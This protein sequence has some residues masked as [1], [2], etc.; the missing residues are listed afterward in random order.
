MSTLSK[1][2][3]S[4]TLLGLP[5][6]AF[7]G[8]DSGG[9]KSSGG[10]FANHGSLGES[11]ATVTTQGA[12][13]TN[14]PGLIE[15]LYPITPSSISDIGGNGLP[16]GW[17]IA[18]FGNYGVDPAAD[19]DGDGTS[20]LMEYLAGTNPNDRLSVF[21]PEGTYTGGLYHLPIQ[22]VTGR[23]YKVWATR[24]LADWV[25]QTTLT[26]DGTERV[27]QFDETTILSGPLYSPKHPSRYYFRVEI[28]I[29]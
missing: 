8:I 7:A 20:N 11:F 12:S 5:A 14:H 28:L 26:G 6:L 25:L 18:N 27:F 24:N 22:T 13:T 4:T 29:P 10:A 1:I 2:S 16:D 19:A 23:D 17:E 9:G 3:L 15:V 21:R